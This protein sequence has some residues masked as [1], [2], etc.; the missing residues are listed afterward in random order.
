VDGGD[1]N[2]CA[3][4][5][6]SVLSRKFPEAYL[7]EGKKKGY[8]M[9]TMFDEEAFA[10]LAFVQYQK[11]VIN[12]S[13][14]HFKYTIGYTPCKNI[15]KAMTEIRKDP[16]V[17]RTRTVYNETIVED[18]KVEIKTVTFNYQL[19]AAMFK[20]IVAE[21]IMEEFTTVSGW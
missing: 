5:V 10:A 13:I 11:L 1:A 15:D 12:K 7:E 4:R 8:A 17:P 19:F 21:L 14:K 9:K 16:V 6:L 2:I 18:G 20:H 3:N